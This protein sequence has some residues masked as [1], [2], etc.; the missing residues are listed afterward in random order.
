ME[1]SRT[2][3]GQDEEAPGIGTWTVAVI[4]G[5]SYLGN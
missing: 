5:W 2:E 3:P 4:G 1:Q